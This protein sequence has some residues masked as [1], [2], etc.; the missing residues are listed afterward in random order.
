MKKSG[1]DI[2]LLIP[3]KHFIEKKTS[4]GLS[5]IFSTFLALIIANSPF[6]EY[7]HAFWKQYISIGF[8]DFVIKKNITHWINDGMM[9]MFF[10]MIGLELKREIMFGELSN[11]RAALLPIGAA[12]GGMLFP[13]LIFSSFNFGTVAIDGW[14]ISIATDIAFA[15]GILYLLGDRVPLSLKIFL[16]A[17]AIIDDIG[18]VLVIAL[19]Y[20]SDI[21]MS[22]LGMAGVFFGILVI[23]NYMGVRNTFFYAIIGIGGLW[24]AVMLSGVHATIAA[25]LAAFC[26][27]T[28]KAIDTP[29]FLRKV[30][31]LVFQIR[32]QEKLAKLENVDNSEKI[33]NTIEKFSALSVEATPPLQR[34]E[35]AF[36]GF[37]SF[38]IL[39]IFAFSN[40]GVT[41]DSNSFK[42]ILSPVAMGVFL[43]LVIGKFMGIVLFTRIM[44]WLKLCILPHEVEWK[45]VY[46]IGFLASI[47]FTMSLFITELAYEGEPDHLIEAKMGILAASLIA[48]LIG[49]FYFKKISTNGSG[50][51]H[52]S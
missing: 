52:V 42:N 18:S 6:A 41:I 10:F 15:L 33:T 24:M 30:K 8:N 4:I 2:Y 11:L 25:V 21:S 17:I 12:I 38:V 48:G 26:I 39:P 27:P 13:A 46:G 50:T 23:A 47:G 9:S 22:N 37:V 51:N 20:T 19:F 32:K 35:H 5:L 49:F 36:S 44:V 31:F 28:T 1:I 14:G 29:L 43:G 45:H 34:L 3:I 16:T 7:Y 40:A